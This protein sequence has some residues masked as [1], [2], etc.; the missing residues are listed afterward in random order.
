MLFILISSQC[1]A[2]P[3]TKPDELIVWSG[4]HESGK[5]WDQ[6][7]PKGYVK[8]VPKAGLDNSRGLEIHM[9]GKGFRNCGLNWKGWYPADACDDASRRTVLVFWIRQI[10][11]VDDA[12]LTVRLIDNLKRDKGVDVSNGIDVV[13]DGGLEKIDGTWRRAVLPLARFADGK[14]LQLNKLWEIDFSSQGDRELTFQI[15]RI[16][17]ATEKVPVQ[18][19]KSGPAFAAKARIDPDRTLHKISDGIYGVVILPR[20][21]LIE[22]RIPI[23]RWGGN[24]STRFNWK[25]GVD[26][27]ASDWFFKNRGQLLKRPE[28]GGYLRNI[29]RLQEIEATAYQTVPTIGWVARDA[30]SY[31]FPVKQFGKQKSTEPG[32]PDVGDGFR[33]D[34]SPIVK[35]DPRATSIPAPPEFIGDAVAFVAKRAGKADA[36]KPGVKYWAL[37]NEPMLWHAT[38]RD[39]RPEPLGYDELWER[40]VRY[41][42]AIKKSDPTAKVAGFCSWGWTDLAYSAKDEGKDK[43]RTKPDFTAHDKVPLAEWF[44]KKCGEYKKEHG[45]ALI[46]VFDVHWYPQGRIKGQEA[47]LGKGMRPE[48]NEYRLRSTRDLWDRGYEQ[49]K[50]VSWIRNTGNYSP[51]ALIP[52]VRAWIDKHN[53]GMEICL[54]E[55]N[56]GGS[57]NITGGLAQVETLGNLA[58]ERLDLA[59]IWTTPEGSQELGWQLFRNYD[60]RRHGFG[61]EFLHGESDHPDLSVFA[62]RR[63]KDGAITIAVVNKNLHGPCSVN[64]DVGTLQGAMRVWRFDQDSNG[65]VIEIEELA[66]VVAGKIE[67]KTPAASASMIVVAPKAKEKR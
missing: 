32:Y 54:G 33:P 40:T 16:G 64:L 1:F 22:Y 65:K 34:G 50:G 67:L 14:P 39:V 6:L 51:V 27:G 29:E 24:P 30:H 48:L 52:R 41:A 28:D 17:F 44:I 55:Y 11:K 45:K 8:V 36:A 3:K 66:R 62:A 18:R 25:L 43:Y 63:T 23:V 19:F 58:R 13:G 60:G 15:D 9:D 42:E 59:F 47:Y 38:H 61:V 57:D 4:A 35:N 46:D 49:E 12:E 26:N 5:T 20:E 37:D 31:A 10:T 2:E 53:P 56:F 21:K 7:G